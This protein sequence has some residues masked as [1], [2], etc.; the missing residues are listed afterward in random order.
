MFEVSKENGYYE[1][2]FLQCSIVLLIRV[3]ACINRAK[4]YFNA[5]VDLTRNFSSFAKDKCASALTKHRF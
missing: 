2:G 3:L 5:S 4:K 1:K